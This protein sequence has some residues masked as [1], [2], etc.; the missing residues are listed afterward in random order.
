M[1]TEYLMILIG[2]AD[3]LDKVKDLA[4]NGGIM[5]QQIEFDDWDIAGRQFGITEWIGV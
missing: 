2:K 1:F 5:K 3:V 4:E